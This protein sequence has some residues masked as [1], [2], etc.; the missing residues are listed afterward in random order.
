MTAV[1][2]TAGLTALLTNGD[3]QFTHFAVGTGTTTPTVSDTALATE[4]DRVALTAKVI[5]NNELEVQAFLTNADGNG[6]LTEYGLW[7]A[8]TGGT[9]LARGLFTTAVS[10]NAQAPA[11]IVVTI[12]LTNG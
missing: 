2:T 7:T 11:V 3:D 5:N 12:T 6:T 10:K 9:L 1:L 4:I 8:A